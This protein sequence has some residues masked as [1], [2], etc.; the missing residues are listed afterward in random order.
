MIRESRKE[1]IIRLHTELLKVKP[2]VIS[3][4]EIMDILSNI[5]TY[6]VEG[7]KYKTMQVKIGLGNI[8]K[9]YVAKDWYRDLNMS[10]YYRLNQI[11][12]KESILFYQ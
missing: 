6:F 11:L 12:V 8:F 10:R 3:I 2:E 1:F 5:I 7:S 9:S 4:K